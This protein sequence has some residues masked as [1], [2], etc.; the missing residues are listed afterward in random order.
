M[1]L[2]DGPHNHNRVRTRHGNPRSK[3]TCGV[4]TWRDYTQ[5]DGLPYRKASQ[6]SLTA[7]CS[8]FGRGAPF[9]E[10]GAQ[11]R[12]TTRS[13]AQHKPHVMDNGR[14]MHGVRIRKREHWEINGNG[15]KYRGHQPKSRHILTAT[16]KTWPQV[17]GKQTK[18]RTQWSSKMHNG[19]R[20]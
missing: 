14:H 8:I 6:Q 2:P 12:E 5:E 10:K 16:H 9:Y 15:R 3:A 17:Q 7:F 19:P 1:S 13:G 11:H 4:S 20:Q 18:R